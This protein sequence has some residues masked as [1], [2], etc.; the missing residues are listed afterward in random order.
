MRSMWAVAAAV[1]VLLSLPLAVASQALGENTAQVV[2]HVVLG[3]GMLL[4]VRA[5]FDFGLP[6]WI[7]AIGA[8]S[9][10]LFAVAFLLQAAAALF[11][12]TPRCTTW[13][14]VSSG[15]GRN[16]Y[17]C[18]ASTPGSWLCCC[19]G[20]PGGLDTLGGPSFLS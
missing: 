15:T 20:Q 16:W 3:I 19:L 8:L 17:S 4:F 11:P 1:T 14:S 10:A 13:P 2:V 7:N 5:I 18:S 12:R 6:R 9:A